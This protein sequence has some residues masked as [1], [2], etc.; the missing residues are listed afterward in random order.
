MALP[1]ERSTQVRVVSAMTPTTALT[2]AIFLMACRLR[3]H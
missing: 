3:H 1:I 2:T